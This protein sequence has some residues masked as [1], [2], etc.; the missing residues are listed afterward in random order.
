MQHRFVRT[1][2]MLVILVALLTVA[3]GAAWGYDAEREANQA[4]RPATDDTEQVD[5][6]T[7]I[8]LALVGGTA[9]LA[10]GVWMGQMRRMLT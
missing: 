9:L 6:A 10:G 5:E 8:C 4:S 7:L 3:V 1:A 2:S